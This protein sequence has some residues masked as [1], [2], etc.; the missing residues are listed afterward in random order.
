DDGPAGK[1]G[2]WI[3]EVQENAD[4]LRKRRPGQMRKNEVLRQTT[5]GALQLRFSRNE[6][7]DKSEYSTP[8]QHFGRPADFCR[9]ELNAAGFKIRFSFD[10]SGINAVLS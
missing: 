2:I 3:A 10:F 5:L 9:A 6:P 4:R 1:A 7:V 8:K